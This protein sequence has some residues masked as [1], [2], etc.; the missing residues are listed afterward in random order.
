MSA[1]VRKQ[2]VS[3]IMAL[4]RKI[5]GNLYQPQ[6]AGTPGYTPRKAAW[7]VDLQEV[8]Q[9]FAHRKVMMLI[10]IQKLRAFENFSAP[11]PQIDLDT[12]YEAFAAAESASYNPP[13]HTAHLVKPSSSLDASIALHW[14]YP[15]FTTA[16]PEYGELADSTN[17]CIDL[18]MKKGFTKDNALWLNTYSRQEVREPGQK[19]RFE[20][21]YLQR[22]LS[23]IAIGLT[24]STRIWQPRLLWLLD[25]R[26]KG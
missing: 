4:S 18:A 13:R 7:L 3:V 6:P 19:L 11:S 9:V 8:S 22:P 23:Y 26:T 14:R 16:N 15:S 10:T 5:F 24:S 12:A 2:S 25:K 1:I 21:L 20:K 17:P